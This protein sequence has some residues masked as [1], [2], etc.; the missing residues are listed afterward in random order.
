MSSSPS[1]CH[2]IGRGSMTS[3]GR[4][5]NG[6]PSR[7]TPPKVTWRRSS[8]LTARRAPDVTANS[9]RAIAVPVS[10]VDGGGHHR[11]DLT[12]RA[13][14]S[15]EPRRLRPVPTAAARMPGTHTAQAQPLARQSQADCPRPQQASR[16]TPGQRRNPACQ[17]RTQTRNCRSAVAQPHAQNAHPVQRRRT[18]HQSL[19]HLGQRPIR[20]EELPLDWKPPPLAPQTLDDNPPF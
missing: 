8:T 6:C 5:M 13:G 20:T 16:S 18:E 2:F 12:D 7:S 14:L 19:V 10:Q 17:P 1:S 3:R 4:N 11:V 15:H 9:A